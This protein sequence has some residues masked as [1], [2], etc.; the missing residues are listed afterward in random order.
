MMCSSKLGCGKEEKDI[1]DDSFLFPCCSLFLL[2]VLFLLQVT[3]ISRFNGTRLFPRTQAKKNTTMQ[4]IKAKELK[5]KLKI[6][7]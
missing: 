1:E 2:T 6:K 3:S 4:V 7:E 5:Q